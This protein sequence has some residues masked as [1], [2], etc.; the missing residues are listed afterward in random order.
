MSHLDRVI[1]EVRETLAL[2]ASEAVRGDQLLFYDLGFTS[3]DLLD[4]IFRLEEAF[5]IKIPEGTL[6]G[7]A[8]GDLAGEDFAVSGHLTAEGRRRL[9][10]LLPDTPAT[11]FP[12][13]IHVQTLPRYCTVAAFTRLVEHLLT[14]DRARD[15]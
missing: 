5:A 15:V 9:M 1:H 7:L 11:V 14:P 3:M 6:A 8:Q 2:G 4:L 10:A 13:R 12:D